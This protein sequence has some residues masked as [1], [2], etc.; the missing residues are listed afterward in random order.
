MVLL[1]ICLARD[2][3]GSMEEMLF[4]Q[5][6]KAEAGRRRDLSVVILVYGGHEHAST[7]HFRTTALIFLEVNTYSIWLALIPFVL[8]HWL[9]SATQIEIDTF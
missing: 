6:R 2:G 4:R 1:H 7:L 8:K 3:I 9:I 5:R